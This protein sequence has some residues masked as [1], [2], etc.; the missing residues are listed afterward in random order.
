LEFTAKKSNLQF[1]NQVNYFLARLGHSGD[2]IIAEICLL[3][4]SKMEK[5]P[6][7][8][9]LIKMGD[10]LISNAI[11]F[12]RKNGLKSSLKQAHQIRRNL[13]I[14]SG[15]EKYGKWLQRKFINAKFDDFDAMH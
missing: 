12:L 6:S 4:S 5:G 3:L 2:A 11:T 13:E 10:D 1:D 9:R 7:R 8:D 15:N 14:V